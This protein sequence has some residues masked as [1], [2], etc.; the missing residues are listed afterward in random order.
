VTVVD[1][2]APVLRC[3][4]ELT[5]GAD[6]D[7]CSAVLSFLP[8]GQPVISPLV[9]V[10]DNCP[11]VTLTADPPSG[12]AFPIGTTIINITA[13]DAAGNQ[14]TCQLQV[15]V[16]DWEKPKIT[17]P[18]NITQTAA[19]DAEGANVSF[20]VGATDNCPG[21]T[22]KCVN[23]NGQ[24]VRSGDFFPVGETVVTCTATDGN[25]N[26][27]TCSFRVRVVEAAS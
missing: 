24:E 17:C 23:Q 10:T 14:S 2:E 20:S 1:D 11:G 6:R 26:T 8:Q 22:V 15:N 27:E 19:P 5:I 4:S 16:V 18:G 21:V 13:T 7:S 3:R 25:G 9:T 12:S